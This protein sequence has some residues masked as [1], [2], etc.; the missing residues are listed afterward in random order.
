MV[1]SL[2]PCSRLENAQKWKDDDREEA[3]T[4]ALSRRFMLHPTKGCQ[5]LLKEMMLAAATL[6]NKSFS[7]TGIDDAPLLCRFLHS[8]PS[9]VMPA[10]GDDI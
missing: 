1:G 9:Y 6:E 10:N 5:R 7:S 4:F 3:S 8:F 2:T